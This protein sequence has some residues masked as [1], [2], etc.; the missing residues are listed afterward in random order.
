MTK[1]FHKCSE[2]NAKICVCCQKSK[3]GKSGVMCEPCWKWITEKM[4][5]DDIAIVVAGIH[6]REPDNKHA[7]E[8]CQYLVADNY[9]YGKATLAKSK[10]KMCIEPD[11]YGYDYNYCPYCM[12][13]LK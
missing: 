7:E 13:K 1:K 9:L 5:I 12:R 4:T 2:C 11:P 8:I 6:H 3:V 10:C